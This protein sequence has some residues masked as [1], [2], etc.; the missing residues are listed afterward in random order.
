MNAQQYILFIKKHG[1]NDTEIAQALGITREHVNRILHGKKGASIATTEKLWQI[2]SELQQREQE[3][4]PQR[5][6]EKVEQAIQGA[7]HK[8]SE[9]EAGRA[10]QVD[11]PA[12]MV[13]CAWCSKPVST[14]IPGIHMLKQIGSTKGV[15]KF[16]LHTACDDLFTRDFMRSP[17]AIK[18]S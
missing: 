14:N 16:D 13:Y 4:T 7:T 2:A 18:T 15:L 6:S 9:Q 12:P 17:V 11:A 10:V 8:A 1:Y 3:K 5:A